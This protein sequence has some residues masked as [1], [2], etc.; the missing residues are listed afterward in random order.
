MAFVGRGYEDFVLYTL[1]LSVITG[2]MLRDLLGNYK[3]KL[4]TFLFAVFIWFF[5]IT[6]NE[7]EQVIEV[8]VSVVNIPDGQVVLN[9]IPEMAKV[10]VH[11]SGKALIALSLSRSIT[12]DLDLSGVKSSKT[13][14]LDPQRVNVSRASGSVRVLE[15]VNPDSIRVVLDDL[16]IKKVAVVPDIQVTT[17]PG[18]TI[19]GDVEVKPDSVYVEG[20]KSLVED[21][22]KLRTEHRVFSDLEYDLETVLPLAPT[23]SS[24]VQVLRSQVTISLDVQKLMEVTLEEVPVRVRNTPP[25]VTVHVVPSTLSLVLEGGAELLSQVS[26]D[27]IVVYINYARARHAPQNE[28]LAVI[29]PPPGVSYRDVKPKSFKL[30]LEHQRSN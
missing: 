29:K 8:P 16:L 3:V 11:G 24:K 9:D 26:R 4:I 30:V 14:V 23:S 17:A 5:V 7:Y 12:V 27:D 10:K 25:G 21:I 6:E 15:I 28:H 18:H 13:F 20:P 2:F 22:D 1:F 19:V